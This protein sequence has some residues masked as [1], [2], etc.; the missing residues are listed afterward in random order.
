MLLSGILILISNFL[1]TEELMKT[2]SLLLSRLESTSSFTVHP[3]SAASHPNSLSHSP[4][5]TLAT[6]EFCLD[7]QFP[8]I[9]TLRVH[10]SA[11]SVGCIKESCL[12]SLNRR[13]LLSPGRASLHG[14][15]AGPPLCILFPAPYVCLFWPVL[16]APHWGVTFCPSGIKG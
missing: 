11:T 5:T 16:P 7:H 10:L 9:H 1:F 13:D 15:H 6:P 3:N 8:R 14:H 12:F 2:Q 4:S